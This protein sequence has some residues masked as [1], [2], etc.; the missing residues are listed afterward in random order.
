[1]AKPCY[2]R[3][4][5]WIS[6]P[7]LVVLL[8]LDALSLQSW[9]H[10]RH[11]VLSEPAVAT[12]TSR[13]RAFHELVQQ[14]EQ[15][16]QQQ[17]WPPFYPSSSSH[18][19]DVIHADAANSRLLKQLVPRDPASQNFLTAASPAP[20]DAAFLA[21][22]PTGP[23]VIIIRRTPPEEELP[24]SD[25]SPPS[26]DS[27][28]PGVDS[29]TTS[30]APS[31]TTPSSS[32]RDSQVS[33]VAEALNPA[34][35][36]ETQ[37]SEQQQC[38]KEFPG[39]FAA[40]SSRSSSSSSDG[41]AEPSEV[42]DPDSPTGGFLRDNSAFPFTA[43][44]ELFSAAKQGASGRCTGALISPCHVLTAGHCFLPERS[45]TNGGSTFRGTKTLDPE[46]VK[47]DWTFIPG[48]LR[49]QRSPFGAFTS[50]GVSFL[51]DFARFDDSSY[52]V[53]IITL[54]R[55]VPAEVGHFKY[56][57]VAE[58]YQPTCGIHYAGYP[59]AGVL[60][61]QH[62]N[63]LGAVDDNNLVGTSCLGRPGVSGAPMWTFGPN[64]TSSDPSAPGCE[65]RYVR[66]VLTG[67]FEGIPVTTAVSLQPD[68]VKAIDKWVSE[69]QCEGGAVS[70]GSGG[71]GRPAVS[72]RPSSGV[73]VSSSSATAVKGRGTA[74]TVS[75]LP[76]GVV[77]LSLAAW[78]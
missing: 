25:P 47:S 53:G 54:S 75:L 76:L 13:L 28:T 46:D 58:D 4:S 9:V 57:A 60:W 33:E 22:T 36:P 74:W 73:T 2:A 27:S 51:S 21:S 6:L 65:E 59:E 39:E 62:C 69:H 52:D 50:K 7:M 10:A 23:V 56:E 3:R 1:M 43:I 29:S 17:Q 19:S 63:Y 78:L 26:D 30:P 49:G 66:A 55:S 16:Q 37:P 42:T 38:P 18:T 72:S 64:C 77:F 45:S 5:A 70:S 41:N 31:D 14:P 35:A 61:Y 12:G 71:S 67:G 40:P 34:L 68:V 48:A 32:A 15:Q 44:G 20:Q 24:P 11:A 8:A